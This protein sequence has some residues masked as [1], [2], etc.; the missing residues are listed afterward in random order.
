MAASG[1]RL[2]PD[3]RVGVGSHPYSVA[4]GDFNAD[5]KQDIAT[6]NASSNSVTILLGD[7]DGGFTPANG[8]PIGVGAFPIFVTVGD[9]NGD[10]KQD[11]AVTDQRLRQRDDSVR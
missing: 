2:R 9:F 11:L 3:H 10:A 5:G 8:S 7:G 6:A 4:V 1:S